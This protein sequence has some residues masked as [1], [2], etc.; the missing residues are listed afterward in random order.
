MS[1]ENLRN[2]LRRDAPQLCKIYWDTLAPRLIPPFTRKEPSRTFNDPVWRSITLSEVPSTLLTLP[3]MQ[4]LR[5]VRQLG[6]AHLLYPG[7]H[8]SRLEHSL[9]CAHAAGLMFDSLSRSAQTQLSEPA[10]MRELIVCAALLHDCGHVV[11]SHAGEK[12]IDAVFDCEWK[13]IR[14]VIGDWLPPIFPN[15]DFANLGQENALGSGAAELATL[16]FLL[17]ENFVHFMNNLPLTGFT[18][19]ASVRIMVSFI[20]GRPPK[21][22]IIDNHKAMHVYLAHIVS[23]DM[24]ADK[25]DYVARDAFYAGLPVSVDTSRLLDQ[26]KAVHAVETTPGV[27]ELRLGFSADGPTAYH[28]FGMAP[29]GISALEL[30]VFT[31]SH[32]FDRIYCHHKVNAAELQIEEII[33]VWVAVYMKAGADAFI[34]MQDL[35]SQVGDDGFLSMILYCPF[36]DSSRRFN[37][38]PELMETLQRKVRNFIER[39]LPQRAMAI[40]SN[41]LAEGHPDKEFFQRQ[42][43][44]I[45]QKES[46]RQKLYSSLRDYLVKMGQEADISICP[47][48]PNPVKEN[49]DILLASEAHQTLRKVNTQFNVEQLANAYRDVKQTNWIFCQSE[50][51][52]YVA[53]AAVCY[54]YDKY[55]IILGDQTFEKAKLSTLKVIECMKRVNSESIKSTLLAYESSADKRILHMSPELAAQMLPE[56]GGHESNAMIQNLIEK[57]NGLSVPHAYYSYVLPAF[58]ILKYILKY[59]E[60]NWGKVKF[61]NED[62][63]QEDFVKFL[64]SNCEFFKIHEHEDKA[65][66]NTDVVVTIPRSDDFFQV[67]ELKNTSYSLKAAFER[68]AGQPAAYAADPSLSPV[69]FLFTTFTDRASQTKLGNAVDIYTGKS[70]NT[71]HLIICVGLMNNAGVPS[72]KGRH[73]RAVSP[74]PSGAK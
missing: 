22:L 71:K 9:G 25:L 29:A 12:V 38:Q 47:A 67:I 63:F 33:G 31:R 16:M 39:K 46:D 34:Y 27:Q 52:I 50:K 8:H 21:E 23:G 64:K 74:L 62:E 24:D 66:G 69:S 17:S 43:A 14:K 11:F 6:V 36:H 54:F 58:M 48:K 7:A 2:A 35:Y 18:A 40:F 30:F 15:L 26:L 55:D 65:S 4:R 28:L 51:R 44:G 5:F 10:V 41:S 59:A 49:P 37:V 3:L 61:T 73:N 13:H 60:C 53:V 45:F 72:Q 56:S 70:E 32:L 57:I 42:L 68:H 19:E 20:V 1:I